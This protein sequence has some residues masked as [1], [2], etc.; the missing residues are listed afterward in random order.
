MAGTRLPTRNLR[1]SPHRTPAPS[2]DDRARRMKT[3]ALL[4]V[5]APTTGS[6]DLRPTALLALMALTTVLADFRPAA[7]LAPRAPT[8]VL[9]DLRLHRTH[10]TERDDCARRSDP[11][12]SLHLERRRPCG[13]ALHTLQFTEASPRARMAHLWEGPSASSPCSTRPPSPH[14]DV[15]IQEHP[16][17]VRPP[18]RWYPPPRP[19]CATARCDVR[20]VD[21]PNP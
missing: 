2:A 19:P 4:A 10:C 18:N 17:H 15:H 11:P 21:Q 9:A 16:T 12:H 13:Q 20:T 5:R 6:Q 7:L 3:T 8:T 14:L 1:L